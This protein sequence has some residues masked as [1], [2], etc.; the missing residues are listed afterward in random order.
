MKESYDNLNKL[1]K[2]ALINEYKGNLF[3][4]LV[5][6][7][8]ARQLGFE[9]AFLSAF[10][11]PEKERLQSYES[12]LRENDREC[13]LA[14]P[15]L[16]SETASFLCQRVKDTP[17][18]NILVIG[19]KWGGKQTQGWDEADLLLV[20]ESGETQGVSLKLCKSH[21]YV[22]TKSGGAK[23]FIEKYFSLFSEAHQLQK[24]LNL[25]LDQSFIEMGQELYSR[26]CLGDFPGRFDAVWTEA[27]LSE[28][29]GELP[30]EFRVVVQK[31]YAEVIANI[32]GTMTILQELN[33]ELFNRSLYSLLGFGNPLMWQLS[34]FYQGEYKFSH[35]D[36]VSDVLGIFQDKKVE[37]YP[38]QSKISSFEIAIG[39]VILQIRVKPM[40]KFTACAHKINCSQ[41]KRNNKN[42]KSH[43]R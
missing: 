5:A 23:S 22:N 16:A 7:L 34:C 2:E 26:A 15:A 8:T 20:K 19:K 13:L 24:E 17:L 43:D 32:Y 31:N 28:L 41:K 35:C 39:E 29:P 33:S 9:M 36:F 11:G 10:E 4:F 1:Q 18:K 40:N 3:E 14:L 21:A 42:G 30:D 25:Q 6:H 12:W 27:K 37:L 38:L